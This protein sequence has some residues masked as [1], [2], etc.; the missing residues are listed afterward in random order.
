ME[1]VGG[2]RVQDENVEG[3]EFSYDMMLF[4]AFV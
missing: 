3:L 2:M 4:F 1:G